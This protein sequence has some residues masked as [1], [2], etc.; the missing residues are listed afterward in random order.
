MSGNRAQVF[1]LEGVLAALVVLAGLVFALQ[2]VVVTPSE[3]SATT[4]PGDANRVDSILF[5]AA[6]DGSLKRSVLAWGGGSF[7]GSTSGTGHYVD[8]FPDNEFGNAL[9]QSFDQSKT[10][11]VVVRYVDSSGSLNSERLVYNGIPTGTTVRSSVTVPLYDSDRLRQANGNL[12]VPEQT[13][14]GSTFYVSDQY[15]G[16]DLYAVLEVEV[17]VWRS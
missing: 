4:G 6:Q 9:T 13:V 10:V 11:N 14:K 7:L 3:S 15:P 5:G 16:N 2:A 8:D 17:V 1:T 12:Q